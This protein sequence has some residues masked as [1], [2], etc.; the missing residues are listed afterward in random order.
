[1]QYNPKKKEEKEQFEEKVNIRFNEGKKQFTA[2]LTNF[3]TSSFKDK[4]EN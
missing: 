4:E 2:F 1:M 3:K